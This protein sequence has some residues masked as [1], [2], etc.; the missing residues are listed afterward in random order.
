M[1]ITVYNTTQ[2]SQIGTDIGQAIKDNNAIID[3]NGGGILK[4]WTGTQ[5][6]YDAVTTKDAGTLYVVKS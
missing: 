5:A 1:T 2:M 3:Q 6:E 4:I